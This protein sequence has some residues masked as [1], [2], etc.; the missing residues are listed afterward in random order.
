V[1]EMIRNPGAAC[2]FHFSEVSILFAAT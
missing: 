2:C 1:T